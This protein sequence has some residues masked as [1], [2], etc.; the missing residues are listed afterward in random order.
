MIARSCDGLI[1]LS[2]CNGALFALALAPQSL[3]R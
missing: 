1:G 3:Y 2:G